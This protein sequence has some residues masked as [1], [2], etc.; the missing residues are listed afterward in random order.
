MTSPRRTDLFEKSNTT[1]DEAGRGST[2][3]AVGP[4]RR[5]DKCNY[6]GPQAEAEDNV[7]HGACQRGARHEE[8]AGRT[9]NCAD[10]EKGVPGSNGTAPGVSNRGHCTGRGSQNIYGTNPGRMCKDGQ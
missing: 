5:K 2:G 10:T 4:G 8:T 7:D 1:L 6:P 9:H 3:P